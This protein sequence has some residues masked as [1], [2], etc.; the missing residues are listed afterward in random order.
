[1]AV[2]T[3][4]RCYVLTSAASATKRGQYAAHVSN[5][6]GS[7]LDSKLTAEVYFSAVRT[8]MQEAS[9]VVHVLVP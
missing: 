4:I 8:T 1:M 9:R 2:Q 5:R 7:V 3:V 6:N